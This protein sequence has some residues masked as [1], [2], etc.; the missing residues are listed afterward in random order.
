MIE[1][2]KEFYNKV[3][4][5]AL[6][7]K[8]NFTPLTSSC[9]K[10]RNSLRYS[11][12]LSKSLSTGLEESI[13]DYIRKDNFKYYPIN[14]A[15]C[16]Q[17]KLLSEI[18]KDDKQASIPA[19]RKDDG[20]ICDLPKIKDENV[21]T[22]YMT[23]RVNPQTKMTRKNTS[24]KSKRQLGLN[25]VFDEEFEQKNFN[26]LSRIGYTKNEAKTY[27][28]ISVKRKAINRLLITPHKFTFSPKQ[29]TE[30]SSNKELKEFSLYVK[31]LDSPLNSSRII[32]EPKTL[33]KKAEKL[34][35]YDQKPRLI[36]NK[37]YSQNYKLNSNYK[38]STMILS[39]TTSNTRK[40]TDALQKAM[41]GESGR[42]SARVEEKGRY[43]LT[44]KNYNLKSF[45]L[46]Q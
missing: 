45:K 34:R 30:M 18:D 41:V 11:S 39:P 7:P 36:I 29:K 24:T 44:L 42:G 3:C 25:L 20:F 22:G 15:S 2:L 8:A 33:L 31:S 27:N 28:A 16:T 35:W 6:P 21:G 14:T 40:V 23:A 43:K 37:Y 19:Q 38:C 13:K 46:K 9:D 10:R 1:D 32:N 26:N 4:T 12:I 5:K 17:Q